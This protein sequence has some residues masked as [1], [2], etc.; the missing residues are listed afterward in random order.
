MIHLTHNFALNIFLSLSM[1]CAASLTPLARIDCGDTRCCC[2]ARGEICS[3]C[4]HCRC[5]E[6]SANC[7][8]GKADNSVEDDSAD[9]G[10]MNAQHARCNCGRV[11][12]APALPLA[13]DSSE[14]GSNTTVSAVDEVVLPVVCV[15]YL[16]CV[17]PSI[18][19]S[20]NTHLHAFLC[21]WVT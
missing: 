2:S 5:T 19:L 21:R 9:A 13:S 16:Y 3:S 20:T 12:G 8:Q 6:S 17:A 1:L 7:C 14:I 10:R 18:E 11:P 4:C 15:D